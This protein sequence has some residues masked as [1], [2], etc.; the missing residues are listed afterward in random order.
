MKAMSIFVYEAH[1]DAQAKLQ[2]DLGEGGWEVTQD[3]KKRICKLTNS[4]TSHVFQGSISISQH[5][6]A[7]SYSFL[8]FTPYFFGILSFIF[9]FS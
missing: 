4:R 7:S 9:Q 3:P 2:I 5:Y 1:T 6:S 8:F